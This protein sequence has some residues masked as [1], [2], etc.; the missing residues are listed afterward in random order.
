MSRLY[1]TTVDTLTGVEVVVKDSDSSA[2]IKYVSEESSGH[3]A[4]LF[5]ALRGAG[6]G[7]FG[8]ITKYYYKSLPHAPKGVIFSNIAFKWGPNFTARTLKKI[9]DWYVNFAKRND[10]RAS[11]A[12]FP[13]SHRAANES[14]MLIQ[15]AYF[16]EKERRMA[17]LYHRLIEKRLKKLYDTTEPSVI[18]HGHSGYW[19]RPIPSL[20]KTTEDEALSDKTHDLPFYD[21]TQ[22]INSSGPNLRGKY[23]SAYMKVKF[24]L[25]QVK[26]MIKHLQIIPEGLEEADMIRSLVQIDSYGGAI[27][28]H[29]SDFTAMAQRDSAVK[30]QFQTY[31]VDEKKDHLHLKWIRDF[32]H[33]GVYGKPRYPGYPD[34]EFNKGKMFQGCYY[35]YPDI[36]LNYYTGKGREGALSLYFLDNF[37]KNP[38]N[39]VD[40]K[41]CWDPE[42][43]FKFAQSIPVKEDCN[44][45]K[46]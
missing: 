37:E 26:E 15:T 38:R 35:N 7:N 8:V 33:R 36:D 24:P 2:Y 11:F 4:D 22:T 34:P 31:W 19:S 21:A 1:G 20:A 6:N 30:L 40:V 42:N 45:E 41:C 3:D 32:Y 13:I 16:D 43:H 5:W 46:S 17:K 25:H 10:N 28:D 14:Q 39:L 44:C 27:N 29:A 23:K 12:L 9:L 18:L